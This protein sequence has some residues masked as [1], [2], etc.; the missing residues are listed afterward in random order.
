MLEGACLILAARGEDTSEAEVAIEHLKQRDFSL[1]L[2][3]VESM[4]RMCSG[5][6]HLG[7]CT[8]HC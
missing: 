7:S 4:Y 6:P 3:A 2:T 1:A 5:M 8:K